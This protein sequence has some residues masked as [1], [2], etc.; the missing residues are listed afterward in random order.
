MFKIQKMKAA[1]TRED[2]SKF[3]KDKYAFAQ[4]S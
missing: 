4:Q 1:H 2:K 3:Q